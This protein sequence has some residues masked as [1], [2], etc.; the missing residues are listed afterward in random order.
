MFNVCSFSMS[1][2]VANHFLELGTLTLEGNVIRITDSL[3]FVHSTSLQDMESEDVPSDD[4]PSAG[5]MIQVTWMG[6]KLT[7]QML[8]MYLENKKRS[9]G[10]GPVSNIT[11]SSTDDENRALVTFSNSEGN[12]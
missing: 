2:S 1:F 9:G 10:G 6:Q 4:I 5:S 12:F 3:P 11:M 7:E 8:K